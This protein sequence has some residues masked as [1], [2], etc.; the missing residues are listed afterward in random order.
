VPR[1]TPI[2][3]RKFCKV[4]E[5]AGCVYSHRKGDHLIYHKEGCPRAIVI[6]RWKEIPEF[7]IL[8]NLKAAKIDRKTYFKLL[9]KK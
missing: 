3:W 5:K 6:P 1:L 4:L 2:H 7:I 8:N 9:A